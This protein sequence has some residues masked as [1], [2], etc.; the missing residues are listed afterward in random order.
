MSSETKFKCDFCGG[1]IV[2]TKSSDGLQGW[3]RSASTDNFTWNLESSLRGPHI[4]TSCV[5]G[6]T[7]Q[8]E[9]KRG[10]K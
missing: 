2:T 10:L 9:F 5:Y 4:C 7:I 6:I 1:N 8:D 3:T